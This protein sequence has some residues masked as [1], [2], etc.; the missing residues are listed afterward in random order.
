MKRE[1]WFGG[2]MQ[3]LLEQFNVSRRF[4]IIGEIV[5][6]AFTWN[7]KR[8]L[9]HSRKIPWTC[10]CRFAWAYVT[11]LWTGSH[12]TSERELLQLSTEEKCGN[13]RIFN[14]KLHLPFYNLQVVVFVHF[15]RRFN[16]YSMKEKV[17]K[18]LRKRQTRNSLL[19]R[20]SGQRK[21]WR[22]NRDHAFTFVVHV[23][24]KRGVKSLY[25]LSFFGDFRSK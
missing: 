11:S 16:F 8:Q 25:Y 20:W 21:K 13:L 17:N 23:S 19:S 7:G 10:C 14:M 1:R 4:S 5:S 2:E 22:E 3:L 24:H 9:T 6:T 15:F 18:I 12:L